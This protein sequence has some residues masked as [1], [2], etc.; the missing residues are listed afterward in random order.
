MAAPLTA[1]D[2]SD[3]FHAL[4]GKNPFPWQ[5]RLLAQVAEAGDWPAQLD[6][7]TGSGKTA[8]IDIALFH[9]ALQADRGAQRAAPVRIIFCVDR[10]LV[11]D[12]A[13]RRATVIAENL[14]DA[15]DG[16]LHRVAT[17]LRDLAGGDNAPPLVAQRLRGGV[18]R[19]QDWARSPCQP[20]ILCT[21]VDQF[22]SRLLFRG[23]GVSDSMKPVHAGL[24]GGDCRIFL[25]E[26]HLA[27]PLRQTLDWIARYRGPGWHDPHTAPAPWGVS[28]LSATPSAGA[29]PARFTLEA[30][31]RD[32]PILKQRLG[33]AK[34]AWLIDLKKAKDEPADTDSPAES[35]ESDDAD[36]ANDSARRL[37]ALCAALVKVHESLKSQGIGTPAIAVI[38]NRVGRARDLFERINRGD[39][40]AFCV[41]HPDDKTLTVDLHL[42]IGPAPSVRRDALAEMLTPIRTGADR[43]LK[44]PLLL[45]TTQ[46]IEA[47]V[48]IDLDGLVTEAAPI[49]SLRQRFGRL[50]RAGRPITSAAA[51]VAARIDISAKHDDPVYGKAIAKAWGWLTSIATKPDKKAD[52]TVDFGIDAFDAHL[53]NIPS[54]ARAPTKDAPVLMPAHVDLLSWTSPRPAQ[55][56]DIALYLHGE[57]TEPD[58]VS[59]IWRADLDFRHQDND[60]VRRLLLLAPPRAA[61]A[62]AL[63]VWAVRRWL[64]R[65]PEAKRGRAIGALADQAGAE[66]DF[67]TPSRSKG[68]V[69][70]CWRGDDDTSCWIAAQEI[71]P[72]DTIIV[73]ARFGGADDYGWNPEIGDLSDDP[74]YAAALDCAAAAAEPFSGRRF[75]LRLAPGLLIG[76]D[77]QPE[78]GDPAALAQKREAKLAG[79]LADLS[80]ANWSDLASMLDGG[81][82]GAAIETGLERLTTAKGSVELVLDLYG[83]DADGRPRGVVLHAR[84]GVAPRRAEAQDESGDAISADDWAGS[85]APR[86]QSLDEHSGDV[87]GW[88]ARFAAGAGLAETLAADV[89]RAGWLHDLGKADPRFQAWLYYGDPLG[90]DPEKILA[91]SGRTLP[92]GSQRKAGLPDKWRHEA[93]SVRIARGRAECAAAHDP[94]LV[95]W[96]I[97]THHGYGRPFFPCTDDK[98]P[99]DLPDLL[100][101]PVVLDPGPGPDSLA[102]DWRGDDWP[103]LFERLK[104]R[105]GVWELARLEAILRL[106]DHRASAELE[107]NTR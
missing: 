99:V 49:D 15:K 91:K 42:L 103:K 37:P 85:L 96:L 86:A 39:E 79:L 65:P 34:P 72:G 2:F 48:D 51:I 30:P 60:Q 82:W 62:V 52:P 87:K 68:K 14:T 23:Y 107:K 92:K 12:D 84:R 63:P 1:A 6:L 78:N 66:P 26:A 76:A 57:K 104:A 64:S 36:D 10:R 13:F 101:A 47:G 80:K 69:A 54:D 20:T 11:V 106:A 41:N 59:V 50:N 33:A 83:T 73:P 67:R 81:D 21:T 89:A 3:Y 31:D 22:G 100:D 45:I 44:K 94:D 38:L 90:G 70:F 29:D 19:E 75:T 43:T 102:F 46:T 40:P 77:D 17:R 25:D 105:Y 95:L 61:E 8:C 98:R 28:Q 4:H 35:A 5:Q 9:L 18:P 93:L 32:H 27:E 88:A 55:D 56:L 16:I 7:P 53:P 24:L 58:A 71:K 97:G 74:A